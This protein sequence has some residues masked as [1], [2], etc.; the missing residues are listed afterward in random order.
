LT[1][2]QTSRYTPLWPGVVEPGST[3][4]VPVTSPDFYP[5]LLEIAGIPLKPE[6][7]VDGVSLLPLL[8]GAQSLEREAIFWHYPHY[9]NQGGTPGS[10]IRVG[11]YK[12][13]H[14][15]EGDRFELYNLREDISEDH[16]LAIKKPY[17]VERLKIQLANWREKI[18]AKI[19]K[20]NLDY[21]ENYD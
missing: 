5:T 2:F 17:L 19:P 10:S 18:E 4:G 8:K 12:L 14:F 21:G 13:I 16:N 3:C 6:Q 1:C 7:H 9:G 15:F 20:P 11:D